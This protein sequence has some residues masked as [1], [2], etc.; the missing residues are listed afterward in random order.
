MLSKEQPPV[1]SKT[2]CPVR[3]LPK[4]PQYQLEKR[5]PTIH[6]TMLVE[7][8]Q[9]DSS[10]SPNISAKSCL[11]NI[12]EVED[13]ETGAFKRTTFTYV[14]DQ[15]VAWFG[16]T[17]NKRKYDLTVEDLNQLLQRIPDD[18]IY[19]LLTSFISTVSNA[20]RKN[21][22][23]KRPKLLCLDNEQ[24]TKLLSRMLLEE[25]EVLEFLKQHQHPNLIRYHG[26]TTNRG[27]IT[28]IALDKH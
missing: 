5:T 3:N 16:Q 9:M 1:S 14:D 28:G 25:A 12:C 11:R 22:F 17:P 21:L 19:P 4:C 6:E 23:I 7:Q 20:G 15:D 13:Y 8:S 24:E 18:K 27:R 2:V 10:C 26:C